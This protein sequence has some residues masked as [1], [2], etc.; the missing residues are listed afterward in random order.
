LSGR[1]ASGS[2]ANAG[3]ISIFVRIEVVSKPQIMFESKAQA[4][5]KAQSAAHSGGLDGV[6]KPLLIILNTEHHHRLSSHE[7]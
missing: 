5:E 2:L 4:D 1:R 3:L 6:F 7:N